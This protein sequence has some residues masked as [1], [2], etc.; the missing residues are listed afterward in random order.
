M[1]SIDDNRRSWSSFAWRERGDEWS[2]AWGGSQSL[3]R[4]TLLPRIGSHLPTDHVL[5]IAPGHGRITQ[6]LL[7]VCTRYTGV[8]LVEGCVASCRQRF[9]D[10]AHAHFVPNDGRSLPGVADA[11]IDFAISWD[12]LVHVDLEVLTAYLHE[13]ARA[14]RPG[15]HAFLHHSNLGAFRGEDGKP[16]IANPHWR[17]PGVDADAVQHA[18]ITAGLSCVAQEL[19]QWSTPH[20]QDCFSLLRRPGAGEEL[21]PAPATRRSEHP[22]FAAE[23]EHLQ[24]IA[25][26]YRRD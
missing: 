22:G 23:M 14:L 13:L 1:P 9:A 8:D 3:W 15:A 26:L 17:D 12:S 4:G 16:T 19:V 10:V 20:L 11:S 21:A 7:P 6:F 18:A 24:R 5:E 25:A 2:A